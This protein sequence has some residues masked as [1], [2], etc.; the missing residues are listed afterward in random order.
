MTLSLTLSGQHRTDPA[1]AI[2][3]P[4]AAPMVDI[5]VPVYNEQAVLVESV[6][7][8]ERFLRE[9]FPFS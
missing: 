6:T 8:L 4:V 2:L 1:A 3:P 9:H 7:T 5:V